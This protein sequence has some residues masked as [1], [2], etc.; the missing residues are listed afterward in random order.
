MNDTKHKN[1]QDADKISEYVIKLLQKYM[2][3]CSCD[4]GERFL[5]PSMLKKNIAELKKANDELKLPDFTQM[6]PKF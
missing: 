2:I 5:V 6:V 4:D 1:D 3:I